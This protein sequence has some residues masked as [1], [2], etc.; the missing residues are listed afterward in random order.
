MRSVH[1]TPCSDAPTPRP[2]SWS[3]TTTV[4]MVFFH[5]PWSA[6]RRFLGDKANPRSPLTNDTPLR[7]RLFTRTEPHFTKLFRTPIPIPSS[8]FVRLSVSFWRS[9]DNPGGAVPGGIFP[10]IGTASMTTLACI[11]PMRQWEDGQEIGDRLR[12]WVLPPP[13]AFRGGFFVYQGKNAN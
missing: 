5:A 4:A 13:L 7:Q 12:R 10:H 3:P 9:I 1:R 8:A 6:P 2:R 11:A